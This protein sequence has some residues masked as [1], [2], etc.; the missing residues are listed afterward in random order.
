VFSCLG[1]YY[2]LEV[3]QHPLRARMCGFGDKVCPM[4][5]PDVACTSRLTHGIRSGSATISTSSGSQDD[6]AERG[7]YPGGCRVS[8]PL[9]SHG[10]RSPGSPLYQRRRLFILSRDR[11]PVVIRRKA[12]G[13]PRASPI[14]YRSQ[15]KHPNFQSKAARWKRLRSTNAICA[16]N[17]A[18][19]PNTPLPFCRRCS[20]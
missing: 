11:R 10:F 20:G 14:F 2:S 1:R 5:A 7:Q 9:F 13:E 6:S 15:P 16:S 19:Y 18:G 8:H 3:V 17:P 12:G 4:R